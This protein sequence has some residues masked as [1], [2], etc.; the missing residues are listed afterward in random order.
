[1]KYTVLKD[2]YQVKLSE[3]SK[4]VGLFWAFNENQ[5]NEGKK[6]NPTTGKY[7]S[8]G[9]G[10]YLPSSNVNEYLKGLKTLDKWYKE[11]IKQVKANEAI[12]YELNNHECFYT[13]DIT[14]ALDVLSDSYTK[15]QVQKVYSDNREKANKYL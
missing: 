6:E 5:F 9:M 2:Q 7:T 1:M 8:I 14:D 13:G 11:A 10:G 15:E 3:L 4:Q 12:L